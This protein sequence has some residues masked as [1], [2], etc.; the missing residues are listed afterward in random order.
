MLA[1]A[2]AGIMYYKMQTNMQVQRLMMAEAERKVQD[3]YAR[4][5]SHQRMERAEDILVIGGTANP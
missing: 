4:S 2:A 1:S 3:P 5:R